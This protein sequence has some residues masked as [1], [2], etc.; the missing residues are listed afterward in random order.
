[1][2]RSSPTFSVIVPACDEEKWLPGCFDA[3]DRAV[4]ELGEP[5]EVVVVDNLSRD[6]TAEIARERGAVVVEEEAKILSKVRNRGAAVATGKYLVFVDADTYMSPKMLAVIKDVFDSG[7]HV[8][9]GVWNVRPDRISIGICFSLLAFIP[10]AMW[11][12]RTS[13]TLFYTTAEAFKAIGGFDESL[14]ALED[15]D[16]GVRLKRLGKQ[17]AL[18]YKNLL[19]AHVV[20]SARKFDEFGDWFIVLHPIKVWKAF[21]NDRAIA[22]DLWYRPR[23]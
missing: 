13:C 5:V 1:M 21:R 10:F 14:Y 17:R 8:G 2:D 9:G 20:T 16:F 12:V 19:R 3:I 4:T 23:R 11:K 18:R 15:A 6:R 22:H 7:R